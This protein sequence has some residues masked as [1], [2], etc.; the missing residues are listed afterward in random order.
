[1]P[2][3]DNLA[4]SWNF[5]RVQGVIDHSDIMF[6]L[7]NQILTISNPRLEYAGEYVCQIL[8]LHKSVSRSI[9]LTILPGN[10]NYIS[11]LY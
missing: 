3:P 2:T 6:S 1:M 7:D 4:V 8:Y 9:T 10:L 5:S 11:Y